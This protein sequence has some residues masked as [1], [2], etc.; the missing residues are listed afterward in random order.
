M[1][2]RNKTSNQMDQMDTHRRVH[3]FT[4]EYTLFSALQI[5]FSKD[6]HVFSHNKTLIRYMKIGIISCISSEHHGLNENLQQKEKQKRVKE[7]SKS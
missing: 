5:I 2:Q 7:Q 4:K 1:E 6:I 3:P